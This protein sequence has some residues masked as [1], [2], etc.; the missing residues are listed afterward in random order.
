MA[1]YQALGE[2]TRYALYRH[3]V[4]VGRPCSIA[5]LAAV[6]EVHPNTVCPHLDRLRKTDLVE[7][8]TDETGSVGRPR[9]LY[10]ARPRPLV[11][12]DGPKGAGLAAF[13]S[14]VLSASMERGIGKL[15]LADVARRWG[16]Q[17]MPPGVGLGGISG[18]SAAMEGLGFQP[19]VTECGC[20]LDVCAHPVTVNFG[21]CPLSPIADHHPEVVCVMHEALA[22]GVVEQVSAV[23]ECRGESVGRQG[24][25]MCGFHASPAGGPCS[26]ELAPAGI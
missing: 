14:M 22:A 7:L 26:V 5:E 13:S 3:L 24:L 17:I 21:A 1:T 10:K 19:S 6:M 8:S 15:A 4:K 18:F 9:H 2:P 20:G 12:L 23:G 11:D 25:R 16:E